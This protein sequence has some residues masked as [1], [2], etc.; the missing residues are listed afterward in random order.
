[1]LN[2]CDPVWGGFY[3]YAVNRDWSH[4]HFEKMLYVQ[5]GTLDNYLDAYQITSDSKYGETAAGIEAYV[6]RFLSDQVDGGFYASQDADVGSHDPGATL[7]FGEDYFSKDEMKR[8]ETG[9]PYVD[10]SLYTDW[11]GQMASAYF[12][13]Y[14]V[15]GDDHARKFALKTVDRLLCENMKDDCMCHRSDVNA[16]IYGLLAD[17]VYF[18]IALVDAYQSTGNKKYLNDAKKIAQ[19]M[20]TQLQDIVQGGFHSKLDNPHAIGHLSERHKPFT[21]NVAAA[22]FLAD[23]HYLTGDDMLRKYAIKTLDNVDYPDMINSILGAGYGIAA[24]TIM[25]HPLQVVIVGR[26]SD[27]VTENM[28]S[29]VLYASEPWKLVQ[30]LD[31]E[32]GPLVIGDKE[33]PES[34]NPAAYIC[35]DKICHEAISDIHILI[36]TLKEIEKTGSR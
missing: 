21:E 2:L 10:E 28:L 3:R 8:L 27:P 16:P 15:L 30:V 14:Q 26:L 29:A 6:N 13:L 25:Y 17:Q 31:P 35:Q 23:L 24:D 33:F 7:I 1:M 11:N 4:P 19:F 32:Q 22:K 12:R 34:V 36:S 18:G 20:I 9:I 5:A